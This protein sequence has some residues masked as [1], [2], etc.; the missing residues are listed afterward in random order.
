MSADAGYASTPLAR[1]LGVKAGAHLWLVAAPPG[2]RVPDLPDGATQATTELPPERPGD[3]VLAFSRDAA[4][5]RAAL[6]ALPAAMTLSGRLWLAWPRRAAG[7]QS[8]IT[9]SLIRELVLPLGLVDVKV[10]AIDRDWSGLCLMWRR[11]ARAPSAAVSG[12]R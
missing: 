5:L 6:D 3:V 11:T 8:D 4:A 10:A 9:E 2:W 12:R 1:K 7:H